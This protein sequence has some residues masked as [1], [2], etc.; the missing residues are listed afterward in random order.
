M[1]GAL[2]FIYYINR[3]IA[4]IVD[5]TYLGYWP[6]LSSIYKDLTHKYKCF[7]ICFRFTCSLPGHVICSST[8]GVMWH[9]LKPGWRGKNM[10]CLFQKKLSKTIGLFYKTRQ[11]LGR[12]LAFIILY[13]SLFFLYLIYCNEV[14]GN[15][16]A[17]HLDLIFMIQ[18]RAIRTLH[19]LAIYHLLNP[20]INL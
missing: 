10:V 19:S 18:K 14:S 2:H 13:Y 7:L 6:L 16:S 11:Y 5:Y 9:I 17:V 12:K 3:S 8:L 20:F 15:V 1:F 4:T